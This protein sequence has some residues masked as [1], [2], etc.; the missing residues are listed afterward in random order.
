[1]NVEYVMSILICNQLLDRKSLEF[2]L[3]YQ[4]E[5]NVFLFFFFLKCDD[6]DEV[7]SYSL[8]NITDSLLTM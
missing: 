3:T 6:W 7:S 8:L 5:E 4:N 2:S 1:M